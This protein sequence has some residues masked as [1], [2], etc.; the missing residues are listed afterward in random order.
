MLR[1]SDCPDPEGCDP[2]CS[3]FDRTCFGRLR[4]KRLDP[5][6]PTEDGEKY[7]N[8]HAVCEDGE[9]KEVNDEDSWMFDKGY[10]AIRKD[11]ADNNLYRPPGYK[12][13]WDFAK[14]KE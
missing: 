9:Q 12:D 13:T 5:D 4:K 7:F 14:E 3:G 10:K 8:T 11:I 2:V 6:H 1:P